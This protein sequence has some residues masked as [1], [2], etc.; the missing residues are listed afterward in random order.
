ML[1]WPE[2]QGSGTQ[3]AGGCDC[4]QR[5]VYRKEGLLSGAEFMDN[6]AVLIRRLCCDWKY[7]LQKWVIEDRNVTD[8][9]IAGRADSTH[10]VQIFSI[11]PFVLS[12]LFIMIIVI[13]IGT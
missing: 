10:C 9:V 3:E 7:F 2:V 12:C 11:N 6:D 5:K 4:K 8:D 1:A 13:L